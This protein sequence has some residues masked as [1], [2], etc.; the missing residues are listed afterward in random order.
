[1]K[2][3]SLAL[4]FLLF[5]C[6]V[7]A[8]H[9]VSFHNNN[10]HPEIILLE[11]DNSHVKIAVRTGGMWVDSL[12]VG[13]ELY[14]TLNVDTALKDLQHGLPSLPIIPIRIGVP[15]GSTVSLSVNRGREL[16][17]NN[18]NVSP[19]PAIS[20]DDSRGYEEYVYQ[21]EENDSVYQ[22][23][24]WYPAVT[25]VQQ[26]Q[27]IMITQEVREIDVYPI[28]F[29]PQNQQI[30]VND[31][32]ILQVNF[33]GGGSSAVKNLGIFNDCSNSLINNTNP[34]AVPY[35]PT[36]SGSVSWVTANETA[37]QC[38]YL[39]VVPDNIWTSRPG[40]SS[41]DPNQ[42][43]TAQVNR[44]ANLRATLSG[45]DVCI[46]RAATT[47]G[48]N[49]QSGNTPPGSIPRGPTDIEGHSA[50]QGIR[51]YVR[52]VFAN[53]TAQHTGTGKLGFLLLI[54]DARDEDGV[55]SSL[56]GE[57]DWLIP[58][59]WNPV[60]SDYYDEGNPLSFHGDHEYAC[61][62]GED[63]IEDIAVGRFPVGN[64]WELRNIVEKIVTYS[65]IPSDRTWKDNS[66]LLE[67][68]FATP[69]AQCQLLTC[70]ADQFFNPLNNRNLI[71]FASLDS[72]QAGNSCMANTDLYHFTSRLDRD[73]YSP[74]PGPSQ[75]DSSFINPILRN[76]AWFVCYTG[77]GGVNKAFRP[78]IYDPYQLF[79]APNN[80]VQNASRLHFVL[81]QSC[82]D[83][84][85]SSI[86]GLSGFPYGGGN[87]LDG[88]CMS[89]DGCAERALVKSLNGAVGWIGFAANSG[90]YPQSEQLFGGFIQHTVNEGKGI[91]G[92]NYLTYKSSYVHYSDWENTGVHY[93]GDPA[94]DLLSEPLLST[95]I[96]QNTTWSGHVIIG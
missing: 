2:S 18:Y 45:F 55:D 49:H 89:L 34:P 77:H 58:S 96:S 13:N 52:Q 37:L 8:A 24:G 91:V 65:I 73:W 76:G 32:I 10:P 70:A 46:V 50:Y 95:E 47:Y 92:V 16:I 85:I 60:P 86:P 82:S 90:W 42:D 67:G 3:A 21:Y 23:S 48:I 87:C 81:D 38:D 41:T 61:V 4:L 29:N 5:A 27:E 75:Q 80:N 6:T 88:V 54:G 1:M 53:G 15:D 94:L 31:S 93:L 69:Y 71:H 66:L 11:S 36:S 35:T 30:A 9:W 84:R 51:D 20:I 39:I 26:P 44:F 68:T 79:C 63:P 17:F 59:G 12:F 28:R 14:Q 74:L 25:E 43:F 64:V 22:A 78:A 19:I 57:D 62:S 83:A 33:T 40:N 72:I 7:Q 56:I